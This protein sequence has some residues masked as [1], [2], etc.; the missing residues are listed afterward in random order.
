MDLTYSI[1]SKPNLTDSLLQQCA[2]LFSEHYGVWSTLASNTSLLQENKL[3][4]GARVRTSVARLKNDQLFDDTCG[5]VIV[6]L[7]GGQVVGHAFFC[8]FTYQS[9]EVCWVTQLLVHSEY[10]GKSIATTLLNTCL[11]RYNKEQLFGMAL[12]SSHP[13]A[14]R[15]LEWTTHTQVTREVIEEHGKSVLSACT[16]PYIRTSQ[17][18]LTPSSCSI[19]THFFV[20]HS[21]VLNIIAQQKIRKDRPW[22]LGDLEEG[23]E[24][25]ALARIKPP[26]PPQ[27]PTRT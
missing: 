11:G 27:S 26:S 8:T 3:K 13:A 1:Y 21:E 14:V 15:A 24:F 10:R 17:L 7:P 16:V 12:V 18:Q 4:P 2:T 6:F 22:L 23:H 19:N 9:K 20:D 5:A 25:F